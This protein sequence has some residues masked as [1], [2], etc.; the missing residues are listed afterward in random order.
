MLTSG[1]DISSQQLWLGY[2]NTTC[3]KP[4]QSKFQ[5]GWRVGPQG[6]TFGRGDTGNF[7]LLRKGD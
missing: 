3:M 5:H 6:L 4:S 7:W 2:L 1:R